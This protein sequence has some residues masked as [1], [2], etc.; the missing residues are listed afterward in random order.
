MQD[1]SNSSL[2]K[3]LELH[4]AMNELGENNTEVAKAT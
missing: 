3:A 1:Y 4:M 2:K